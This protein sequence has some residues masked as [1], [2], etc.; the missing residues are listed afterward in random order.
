MSICIDRCIPDSRLILGAHVVPG[1]WLLQG[2]TVGGG[3]SL[4][5]FEQEFGAEERVRATINGRNSFAVL[6]DE[7]DKIAAGSDGVVFLPYMAGERSP[8]WDTNAKGLFYGLDFSKTRAH[9]A[10]AVMEGVAYALRHNLE[11]A[12]S[13]GAE[14]DTMYAM[15][16]AANSLVWTQIKADVTGK[17]I[18]VPSADTATALGAAILAGVGTGVYSSFKAA[19]DTTVR[20]QREHIPNS[21]NR[22]VYD[23]GYHIYRALYD[24]L[25]PIMKGN[26]E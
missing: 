4:K 3:G 26:A 24:L 14:V 9:F 15:G 1:M 10:R 11:T 19:V 5:W 23:K 8:I 20:I 2:G 16:G 22:Q 25:K 6:D 12:Q 21:D 17:H 13:V 7:A 18:V